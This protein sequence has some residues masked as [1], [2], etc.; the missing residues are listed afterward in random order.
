MSMFRHLFRGLRALANRK[1][2]DQDIAD[3]VAS[4]LEQAAAALVESGL[5]PDEAR[6]VARLGGNETTVREQVRSYGWENAVAAPFSDLR[7]AGRRLRGS[8]G[9]TAVSVLTL[10]LPQFPCRS[11]GTLWRD[12][13]RGSDIR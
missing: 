6:R 13:D 11:R 12:G 10:V 1:A 5:S 3:E 4:Y 7:Y 8:P 2:V 9:F